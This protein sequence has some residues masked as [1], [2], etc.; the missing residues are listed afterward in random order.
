MVGRMFS[1]RSA[2]VAS[3][4]L[5]LIA[6]GVDLA[7]AQSTSIFPVSADVATVKSDLLLWATAFLGVVLAIYGF[8]K[9]KRI[10]R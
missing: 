7:S 5:V 10:A 8:T 2:V 6:L 1:V 9:I 3:L 4:A